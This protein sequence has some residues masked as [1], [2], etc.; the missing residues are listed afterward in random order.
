MNSQPHDNGAPDLSGLARLVISLINSG[1]IACEMALL[2]P[3]QPRPVELETRPGS[4]SRETGG[5]HTVG[6]GR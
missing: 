1:A 2:A 5:M 4:S 3:P 6:A